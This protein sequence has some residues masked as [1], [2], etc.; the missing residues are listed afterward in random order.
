LMKQYGGC[1]TKP[2]KKLSCRYNGI[3]RT[4]VILY[5]YLGFMVYVVQY[6]ES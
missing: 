5:T 2:S 4:I 3:S 6:Y 1:K